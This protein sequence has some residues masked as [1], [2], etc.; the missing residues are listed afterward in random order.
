MPSARVPIDGLWR[1]LCPSIDASILSQGSRALR[2][3]LRRPRLT[4]TKIPSPRAVTTSSLS[5]KS[6]QTTV[7]WASLG[8]LSTKVPQ[9]DQGSQSANE[10]FPEAQTT[11]R[12][13]RGYGVDQARKKY[14]DPTRKTR[15]E[16]TEL[17][18][19]TGLSN[20]DLHARLKDLCTAPNNYIKIARLVAY[21]IEVRGEQPSVEHYDALIRANSDA[22]CGSVEIVRRLLNEMQTEGV[23][24]TSSVYHG[25][26]QVLVNHPDYLFRND[27]M[28]EMREKWF[29]L[30]PEGFHCLV[31][32]HLRDRELEMA[33]DRLEQMVQDGLHVQPWLYDIFMYQLA[34]LDEMDEALGMLANRYEG[35]GHDIDP[36][37]WYYM[38]DKFSDAYHVSVRPFHCYF[39][40]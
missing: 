15:R 37:V 39:M 29:G 31:L 18:R 10:I 8:G 2:K 35:L 6:T 5:Q 4:S 23:Q 21:L 33:M 13:E 12:I 34:E 1:C 25:I 19:Y 40:S 27:I 14:Q 9:A 11:L 16:K 20:M 24:P 30:S 22:E 3:P 38:L 36:N 17:L 32:A 26:L 7:S 28:R